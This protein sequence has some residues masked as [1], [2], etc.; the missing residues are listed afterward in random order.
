MKISLI[1]LG[2]M[3]FASVAHQEIPWPSGSPTALTPYVPAHTGGHGD[4]SEPC[5][6]KGQAW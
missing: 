3:A 1:A 2:I 5:D 6:C 4:G